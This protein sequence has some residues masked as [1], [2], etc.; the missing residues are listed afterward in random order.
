MVTVL[1][2]TMVLVAL[3]VTKILSLRGTAVMGALMLAAVTFANTPDLNGVVLDE[4]NEPMPFVNV[5]LISLPDSAYVQGG[6]TDEMGR[7]QISTPKNDGLLKVSCIG[8]QTQYLN[9]APGLTI[10]MKEDALLL[11]E[12]VV[13]S[14]LPKTRVKGEAMRTTVEGTILEKAGTVADALARVPSLEAKRD[15]AVTV[16][17]RGEAE[18]YINGRKVQDVSELSR[19]RSDQIQHVDVIQNP[20]ARYAASTKAV[21]KTT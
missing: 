15:G 4:K 19:L 5:V 17:G 7:F 1:I 21:A 2:T 8:Y 18:V 6:M 3:L 20:G 16:L 14:Q 11:S 12:V 13:R 10:Q 9:P